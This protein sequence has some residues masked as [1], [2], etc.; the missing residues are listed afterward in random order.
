MA[1][2]FIL[3]SRSPRR[4]ELLRLIVP[5]DRIEVL[6]PTSAEEEGFD[7]LRNWT[8][9]EQRLAS[10]AR[11]KCDDV[12]RQL[13]RRDSEP[14]TTQVMATITADTVIVATA[15]DG[16]LAVLGQPP[17]D[18]SWRETVRAWFKQYYLGRTHYAM[19]A[20]CVVTALGKRAE[21]LVKS[22]VTFDTGAE[23]WLDWYLS[24]G[25]SLGKAGGYGIQGAGS[26]FVSRVDGSQSNVIGLPLS[27]L[28]DVFRELRID[29]TWRE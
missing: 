20:F 17:N 12:L 21:R 25:E 5:A 19:T 28:L 14:P 2:Q 6:P 26:L 18:D 9:L 7:G 3:G 13:A 16:N 22:E 10:I 11:A 27:E 23:R 15:D 29:E 24:T 4:L 1:K 8:D